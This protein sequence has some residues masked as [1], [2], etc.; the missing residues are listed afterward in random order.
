MATI[1]NL[2]VRPIINL[3]KS[4]IN[5]LN[6]NI[7]DDISRENEL[8]IYQINCKDCKSVATK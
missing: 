2:L 7:K 5:L 3:T 6:S 1:K 4:S 8:S